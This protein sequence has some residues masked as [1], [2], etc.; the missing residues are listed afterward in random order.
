MNSV[1]DDLYKG[2]FCPDRKYNP[3]LEHYRKKQG[4]AFKRYQALSEKLEKEYS[5]ELEAVI[6]D[7]VDLLA[8]ELEE[9]FADG[10]SFGIRLMCEVFGEGDMNTLL[11]GNGAVNDEILANKGTQRANADTVQI[12]QERAGYSDPKI[13]LSVYSHVAKDEA[14]RVVKLLDDELFP[15]A[16]N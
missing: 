7:T 16:G 12:V 10:L 14:N 6:D 9:N 8:I 5:E 3:I 11:N 15:L 2:N 13:T 1:I 4:E